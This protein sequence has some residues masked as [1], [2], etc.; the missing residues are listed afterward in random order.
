MM[1]MVIFCRTVD[2]CMIQTGIGLWSRVVVVVPF[3]FLAVEGK[4][5][6]INIC[7]EKIDFFYS[8]LSVGTQ[9]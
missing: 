9:K 3:H 6:K 8:F 2:Y 5:V 1:V 7:V 4:F